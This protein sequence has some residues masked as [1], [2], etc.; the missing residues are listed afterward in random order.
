MAALIGKDG[1]HHVAGACEL[2]GEPA[3]ASAEELNAL[4]CTFAQCNASIYHQDCLEKYLKR[5]GCE[6]CVPIYLFI[7]P[8]AR[9][10]FT[11]SFRASLCSRARDGCRFS[12]RTHAEIARQDFLVHE[13]VANVKAGINVPG[14]CDTV[15]LHVQSVQEYHALTWCMSCRLIN[16]ILSILEGK[17]R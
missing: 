14:G 12:W 16:R 5:S 11:E 17:T 3:D 9:C 2:C 1:I 13:G 10:T 8:T 6:K 15:H 4:T 7:Q